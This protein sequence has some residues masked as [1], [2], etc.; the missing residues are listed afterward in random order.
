MPNI[1]YA[2]CGSTFELTVND[3]DYNA[4]IE[5][6]A[7]AIGVPVK[8]ADYLVRY[9][10]KQSLQDSAAQPAKAAKDEGGDVPAAIVAA[11]GKRLDAIKSGNVSV[12]GGAAR[13]TDPFESMVR[14][15]IDEILAKNA[16]SKGKKLPKGDELVALRK[17]VYDANKSAIDA[18]ANK[19][20]AAQSAIDV[21]VDFDPKESDA[22]DESGD[23][24]NESDDDENDE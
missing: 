12:R 23:D 8:S 18:E 15:V 3:D 20:L 11:M 17:S 14:K 6:V 2:R 22:T 19:R 24:E 4:A 21:D 5:L 16:K 10:F 7:A 13:V 9:G 1:A